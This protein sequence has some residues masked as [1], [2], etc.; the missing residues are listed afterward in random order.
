M[1][2]GIIEEIGSICKIV[3]I[4]GGKRIYIRARVIHTDMNIGDSVAVNGICLTVTGLDKDLFIVEAVGETL[5]KTSI[6]HWALHREVNLER[7]VQAQGRLGGHFVQGHVN[8]LARVLRLENRGENWY[9]QLE[10]PQDLGMYLIREGSLAVDGIS[11]TIAD[12]TGRKIGISIIPHTYKHTTLSTWRSG[13]QVNVEVD[14][15]ARYLE[16]WMQKAETNPR[17]ETFSAEWFK[18]LGY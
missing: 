6:R 12:I 11:L 18:N 4:R 7:A 10:I 15:L 13:Q 3:P 2:T 17:R 1:F 16:K 5:K 9:L 8:G 14:L